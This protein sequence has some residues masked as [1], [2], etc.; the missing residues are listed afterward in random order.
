MAHGLE[1]QKDAV[2]SGRWLLYR[3]N[4][5]R[6]L[7]GQNPLQLDSRPPKLSVP[8]TMLKEGRFKM[9]QMSHPRE[10]ERLM[11][12]AQADVNTRWAMYEYLAHRTLEAPVT[13]Q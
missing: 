12:E 5:D 8:E 3:F 6:S 1:H 7:T 2:D 11:E 13:A 9:L 4:P 10:M